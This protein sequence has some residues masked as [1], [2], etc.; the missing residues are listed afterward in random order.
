MLV[1]DLLQIR[2]REAHHQQNKRGL[3]RVGGGKNAPDAQRFMPSGYIHN[4]LPV[5]R[6]DFEPLLEQVPR[7]I[8]LG[9][10]R[11]PQRHDGGPDARFAVR[12]GDL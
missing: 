12:V 7:D 11:L 8:L 10:L 2:R 6:W 4:E 1:R 3:E 5:H 9:R